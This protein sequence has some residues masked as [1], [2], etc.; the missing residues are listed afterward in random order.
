MDLQWYDY[1]RMLTILLCIVALYKLSRDGIMQWDIFTER[2]KG[3]WWSMNAL[4]VLVMYSL[5]ENILFNVGFG[6]RLILAMIVVTFTIHAAFKKDTLIKPD[7]T[8]RPY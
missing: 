7:K 5:I 2:F 3:L 4:L 6:G 1:L 8:E